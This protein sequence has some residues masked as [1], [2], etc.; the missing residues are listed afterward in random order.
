M[1]IPYRS[2]VD[3]VYANLMSIEWQTDF[4]RVP[5]RCQS[6]ADPVPILCQCIANM[7]PIQCQSYDNICQF[8]K[9]MSTQPNLPIQSQSYANIVPILCQ[10][11]AIR[12]VNPIVP[13]IEIGLS[14][15]GTA[16]AQITTIPRQ[17]VTFPRINVEQ[18]YYMD[19]RKCLDAARFQH[20]SIRCRRVAEPPGPIQCRSVPK[21]VPIRCQS[22][23]NPS[24]QCQSSP[25]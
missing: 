10:S 20:P 6:I 16:L 17:S 7:V 15:I 22:I 5:I 23:T 4:N 25:I 21:P 9:P 24:I 14:P 2:D 8:A 1:R 18:V 19:R 3:P 12:Y 11:I 13:I